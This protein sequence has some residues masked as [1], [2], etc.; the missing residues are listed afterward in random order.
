MKRLVLA[1]LGT[2]VLCAVLVSVFDLDPAEISA[3]V[4]DRFAVLSWTHVALGFV[5]YALVYAGRAARLAV[6]LPGLD[7]SFGHLVSIA[8][9]HNL[10]NLVLP[11]RSGEISLPWML[12]SEAGRTLAEGTAVLLVAR[13]LDLSCVATF[14]LLGLAVG[15]S[16][17]AGG[18]VGVHAALIL[19]ALLAGLLVSRPLCGAVARRLGTEDAPRTG[20]AASVAAPAATRRWTARVRAFVARGASHLA[21][22]PRGRLLAAGGVSLVT[23]GLTYA[24]LFVLLRG[25]VGDDPVGRS[26]AGID[27]SMHLL[28]ATGLHLTSILP[29]NTLA[30]VGAWEA[31]WTAGYVFAGLDEQAA[32]V[33]GIVSHVLVFGF[34]LVLGGLG[35]LARALRAPGIGACTPPGR[36]A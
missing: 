32:G 15:R 9:R 19:V 22:L 4:G 26:L 36:S 28:G 8:A 33:S 35:F 1:L 34:I 27:G 17:E 29:V 11:L 24:S 30:G 16:A 6:L 21:T 10:L 3:R 13:V 5:L 25:M 31:G 7:A 2:A 12:R 20:D 14:M 23:W 18:D